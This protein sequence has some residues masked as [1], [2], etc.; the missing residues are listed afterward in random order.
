MGTYYF[1]VNHTTDEYVDV[2]RVC[3][4][5]K[6]AISCGVVLAYLMIPVSPDRAQGRCHGR[7]ASRPYLTAADQ[8]NRA[9]TSLSAP[10]VAIVA[11]GDVDDECLTR[12]GYTDITGILMEDISAHPEHPIHLL[13]DL[14]RMFG[15]RSEWYPQKD[16]GE[17]ESR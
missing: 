14:E 15:P 12:S 1:Y 2:G 11:D 7:W 6:A 16:G 5:A 8:V 17:R 10:A 9:V 4:D 13:I 3:G